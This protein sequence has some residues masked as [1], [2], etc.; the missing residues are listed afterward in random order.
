MSTNSK[1]RQLLLNRDLVPGSVHPSLFAY[2]VNDSNIPC[3]N[4]TEPQVI[5][6]QIMSYYQTERFV[7]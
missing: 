2:L 5:I 6:R 4:W 1:S 7:P 3:L